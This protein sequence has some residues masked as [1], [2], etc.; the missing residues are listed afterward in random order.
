LMCVWTV[1]AKV[2]MGVVRFVPEMSEPNV[3]WKPET[4]NTVFHN[5]LFAKP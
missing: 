5:G 2:V 4:I 1:V 3:L